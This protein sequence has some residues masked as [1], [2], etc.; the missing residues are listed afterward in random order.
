ML[1]AFYDDVWMSGVGSEWQMRPKTSGRP[2]AEVVFL[3]LWP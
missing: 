2:A 1:V 3:A